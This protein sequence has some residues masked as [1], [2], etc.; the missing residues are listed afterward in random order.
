MHLGKN[1]S[2]SG[3]PERRRL[4]IGKRD[5]YIGLP[6]GWNI[7]FLLM[8][9]SICGVTTYGKSK[10]LP[11]RTVTILVLFAPLGAMMKR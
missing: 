10:E 9:D 11:T 8:F 3:Q 6:C 1:D 4:A 7:M 5:Q 2:A